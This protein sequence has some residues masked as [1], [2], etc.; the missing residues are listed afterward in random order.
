MDWSDLLTALGLAA[1]IEGLLYAAFP[2]ATKQAMSEF[3]AL[4]TGTR[5][6]IA[7]GIAVAGL[8]IVWLVRR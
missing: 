3:M 8:T 4:P 5:R 2:E 6:G 1:V 7:I